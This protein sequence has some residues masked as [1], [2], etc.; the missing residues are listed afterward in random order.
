MPK[1]NNQMNFLKATVKL[2]AVCSI[3]TDIIRQ[4]EENKL[5]VLDHN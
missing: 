3:F 1:I 5:L 2:Y 4:V